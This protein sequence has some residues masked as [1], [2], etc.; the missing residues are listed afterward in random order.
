MSR[1]ARAPLAAA[2]AFLAVRSAASREGPRMRS[3]WLLALA[4]VVPLSAARA[5]AQPAAQRPT[6]PKTAFQEADTNHDGVLDH[7]ELAKRVIDLFYLGDKNK[8]GF[9]TIEE[10]R[11]VVA[12][13]ESAMKGDKN[14]DGKLS[15]SEFENWRFHEFEA[16]DKNKDGVLSLEEVLATYQESAPR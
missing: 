11:G 16:A 12:A 13:P 15:L 14:G 2:L 8:D 4:C 6:D 7:Q 9:L 1:P 10:L 3:T 5:L